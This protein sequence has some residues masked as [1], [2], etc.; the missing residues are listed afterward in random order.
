MK[1]LLITFGLTYGGAALSLVQPFAGLLVYLVF[2]ILRPPSLWF[3]S[4]PEG[5]YSRVVAL[6][7]LAGWV[8]TAEGNWQFGRG[9]GPMRA[10]VGLLGWSALSA[11][12]NG[13]TELSWKAVETLTKI[14]LPVVVGMTLCRTPQRLW[15]LAWVIVLAQGYVA[16]ELNLSYFA[17]FN[18]LQV[19]GLGDL[20]NNCV[21]IALVTGLGLAAYLGLEWPGPGRF[22]AVGAALVML[23]A[24]LFSFSRGGMLALL[25]AGIAG[26]VVMPKRPG[27]L[28]LFLIAMV[29]GLGLAGN[30]VRER[31]A[32]TFTSGQERDQSASTRLELWKRCW[33]TMLHQPVVGIGPDQWPDWV[34]QQYQW[35]RT[36]EAHSLWMQTGAELGFPGLALLVAV[37]G[38]CLVRL[39]PL[40]RDRVAGV[41]EWAGTM[42]RMVITGLTGFIVSAS[43]VSLEALEL[44]YF[45]VLLGAA[46]LKLVETPEGSTLEAAEVAWS[47]RSDGAAHADELAAAGQGPESGRAVGPPHLRGHATEARSAVRPSE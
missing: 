20:D 39:W 47:D 35:P 40:A 14:V 42:A 1:G 25:V 12:L 16:F 17:G 34:K 10:L 9:A 5:N 19:V 43:F 4:V 2:A 21:A 44:P 13:G 15:T 11:W 32:Q 26:F 38:L 30:E 37:Y 23:H 41:P 18:R 27:N 28:A 33:D 3:W 7:L 8:L 46:T 31:F 22:L 6:G 29:L 24:V 36:Q 45:V